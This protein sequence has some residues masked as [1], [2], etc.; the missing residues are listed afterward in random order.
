ML[1][2]V[3]TVNNVLS[4]KLSHVNFLL[5]AVVGFSNDITSPWNNVKIVNII[6]IKTNGNSPKILNSLNEW[7]ISE[8]SQNLSSPSLRRLL[9][10]MM[11]LLILV[12]KMT[13]YKFSIEPIC[14]YEYS[15]IQTD[16][17]STDFMSEIFHTRLRAKKQ[18]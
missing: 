4:S 11:V 9:R 3:Q 14:F 13:S 2:K 8:K 1:S 5:S 16:K 12:H 7:D 10:Q 18:E 6:I 17:K 15:S